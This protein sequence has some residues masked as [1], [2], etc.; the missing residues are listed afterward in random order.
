M[1]PSQVRT[2]ALVILA[3]GCLAGC[4]QSSI[5]ISPDFGNAVSQ[6][7]AA[8]IADPDAH[9]AGIVAPGSDGTRASLAQQRYQANDV[10]QPSSTTAS[11]ASS[12]GKADNGAGA[13]AGASSGTSK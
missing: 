1:S 11:S 8:Q 5:R 7:L 2:A 13:S 10:V 12:I 9:Y 6:D 3:L 4:A